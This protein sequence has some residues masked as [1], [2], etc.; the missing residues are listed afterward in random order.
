MPNLFD[1]LAK[2]KDTTEKYSNVFERLAGKKATPT[3][4]KPKED[5]PPIPDTIVQTVTK[6]TTAQPSSTL[7]SK[8]LG[9]EAKPSIEPKGGYQEDYGKFMPF[10]AGAEQAVEGIKQIADVDYIGMIRGITPKGQ[11]IPTPYDAQTQ[12]KQTVRPDYAGEGLKFAS[13]AV[14]TGFGVLGAISPP[15]AGFQVSASMVEAAVPA[16]KY[17]LAPA[18]S[19]Y[20]LVKPVDKQTPVERYGL[21]LV[22]TVV[23]ILG[24]YGLHA[25]AG[26]V[27]GGSGLTHEEVAKLPEEV[28]QKIK[29]LL[30]EKS[31]VPERQFVSSPVGLIE[32]PVG[33]ANID[34]AEAAKTKAAHDKRISEGKA[35]LE[36][37]D[38]SQQLTID[39]PGQ[40]TRFA[41]DQPEN[42]P[43]LLPAIQG[44]DKIDI[45]ESGQTHNEMI[46]DQNIKDGKRGFVD[47]GGNFLDRKQAMEFVKTNQPEVHEKL[48][49]SGVEELHT[50]PY[51][52]ALEEVKPRTGI[53]GGQE[54]TDVDQERGDAAVKLKMA[55]LKHLEDPSDASKA[56][57]DKAIETAKGT[58]LDVQVDPNTK[59]HYTVEPVIDETSPEAVIKSVDPSL[60]FKGEQAGNIIFNTADDFTL[61]VPKEGFSAEAVNEQ[62]Q[63][64]QEGIKKGEAFK[65]VQK[66]TNRDEAIGIFNKLSDEGK[67][68]NKEEY[69][70]LSNYITS[71]HGKE[72]MPEPTTTNEA[73]KRL[74][75]VDEVSKEVTRRLKTKAAKDPKTYDNIFT[76]AA[77]KQY[78][79]TNP[80]AYQKWVEDPNTAHSRASNKVIRMMADEMK[81]AH[82]KLADVISPGVEKAR[83]RLEQLKK[84]AIAEYR[85]EHGGD[86]ESAAA[87]SLP[88]LVQAY[89]YGETFIRESLAPF[90]K[91]MIGDF[92]EGIDDVR[93]VLAP[94]T[95]GD[96]ARESGQ[97]F[98]ES[99]AR[100][101]YKA[102]VAFSKLKK[103]KKYFNSQDKPH[104]VDYIYDIQTGDLSRMSPEES[105]PAKVSRDA[106]DDLWNQMNKRDLINS[107][108]ENYFPQTSK[109]SPGAADILSSLRQRRPLG[110][111]KSFLKQ[112]TLPTIADVLSAGREPVSY[113][114]VELALAQMHQMN[115]AIM[116]ADLRAEYESKG[117]LK[118]VK[119]GDMVEAQKG[120][121]GKINDSFARVMHY[122]QDVGGMVMRGEWMAP[123]EV[124][125]VINNYLDPGLADWKVIGKGYKFLRFVGNAL[126]Q[127]QL[128]LSAFH[129]GMTSI[130]TNISGLA[131]AIQRASKGKFVDA[132]KLAV[133]SQVDFILRAKEG[134]EVR[135]L[136]KS[137][138][139]D[140][141][142]QS[143]IR[144]GGRINMD[145]FYLNS[146]VDK[147]WKAWR[148]DNMGEALLRSPGALIEGLSKPLM[149]HYVPN[150]KVGV[151]TDNARFILEDEA[152]NKITSKQATTRLQELW[153]STENRLGQLTYDNLFWNRALKDMAMI[154]TRSLGWN[155]GTLREIGGAPIDFVNQVLGATR[156]EGFRVTPKMAYVIALPVTTALY[157]GMYFYLRNG[158]APDT[159]LDYYYPRTGRKNPDGTDE[160][161]SLPS[162]MKD[163]FA[164]MIQPGT[165]IGHKINPGAAA[166]LQM[167]QN[168]D[169]YNTNITDEN[170]LSA[171][172]DHDAQEAFQ[173]MKDEMSFVGKQFEPFSFRGAQ[174]IAEAG[175][176][177]GEQAQAFAGITPA[178]G[179]IEESDAI[180]AMKEITANK[181]T[182]S[183]TKEG[184][185]KRQFKKDFIA[186]FKSQK[187]TSEDIDGAYKHQLI[188][189]E[190]KL[191]PRFKEQLTMTS[192]EQMFKHLTFK[193]AEK[194][195]SMMSQ[196][197][198]AQ[199]V[200]E[201]VKKIDSERQR[202][203]RYYSPQAEEGVVEDAQ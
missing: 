27:K 104:N 96:K 58:G 31:A 85:K 195:F 196:E 26:R 61:A 43:Q 123:K 184:S 165:T 146:S 73:L 115:K 173:W 157:G 144:A 100:L 175:G 87:A 38:V 120:G 66:A 57:L 137:G 119:F 35:Q 169:F 200:D 180:R 153:D 25:L 68:V 42:L 190:G 156:G 134:S 106:F 88:G 192:A 172:K 181:F 52:A 56:T 122:S 116:L 170:L 203:Q 72:P 183:T 32:K 150:L 159:L 125:T 147:F 49:Q 128:G 7:T 17:L 69:D 113:N 101:Q 155:L 50:Q 198:R 55:S 64:H 11:G 99:L 178:A 15:V 44:V 182:S 143:L 139:P 40:K 118:F 185:E 53:E 22:D 164:Y 76:E 33:Q 13:G 84:E 133:R 105:G 24:A 176:N 74:G 199:Y 9:T 59:Q 47:P 6:M 46:A 1:K 67:I 171:I 179:F 21:E 168:K 51:N 126:N 117:L 98:K 160:R 201:M 37:S 129:A 163:V 142:V 148:G 14:K 79:A 94:L 162:Y 65:E 97:I 60:K 189:N 90:A 2:K 83:S 34:V 23:N 89:K 86:L 177:I 62:L 36:G 141:R 131:S 102:D 145:P 191:E 10:V 54:L 161:V 186:K 5:V 70:R 78:K 93:S 136:W 121:M 188:D 41:S 45:G 80:D 39:T 187:L 112:R 48:K 30:P 152:S 16:S 124:A 75:V 166:V 18:T 151:F 174:R 28:Q 92:A 138:T 111:S 108:L 77:A 149:E 81:D 103:A 82:E 194:I 135:K 110:G 95:R 109:P 20:D 71:I 114:P 107:Y 193:E 8:T 202:R 130:D 132:A 63:S 127:V 154:S 12:A 19:L 140:V 91:A 167:I 158:K 29:G 4:E 197:E 3:V